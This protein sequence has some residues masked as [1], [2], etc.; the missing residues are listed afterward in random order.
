[1][2]S[3]GVWDVRTFDASMAELLAAWS[4]TSASGARVTRSLP[5]ATRDQVVA[6][7]DES[8]RSAKATHP[9]RPQAIPVSLDPNL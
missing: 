4:T 7:F 1:M 9:F 3:D 6:F 8:R 5:A 2:A